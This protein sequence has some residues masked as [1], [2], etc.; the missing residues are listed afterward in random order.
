M[1]IKTTSLLEEKSNAIKSTNFIA[2]CVIALYHFA[3]F[4][5]IQGG[6]N[7]KVTWLVEYLASGLAMSVFFFVT[8]FLFFVNF[9]TVKTYF[10]KIKRR[11]HSLLIPYLFWQLI[12]CIIHFL[13]YRNIDFKT[14]VKTTFLLQRYPPDGPLWHMYAVFLLAIVSPLLYYLLKLQKFSFL[15]VFIL[16]VVF[17]HFSLYEFNPSYYYNHFAFKQ[18][19]YGYIP[20]I[21]RY[22][23]GYLFGAFFG[24]S[25]SNYKFSKEQ[26]LQYVMIILVLSF[27][28]EFLIPGIFFDFSVRLL[29]FLIIFS[30]PLKENK[31]I[32]NLSFLIYSLHFFVVEIFGSTFYNVFFQYTPFTSINNI[33]Y[34]SILF[35]ITLLVACAVHFSLNKFCKNF[36]GI[37]CGGRTGA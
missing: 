29:P 16:A 34:R 11:I 7:E 36:L 26:C 8:G 22:L 15:L 12:G 5:S 28:L 1:E 4:N 31:K 25:L 19:T 13:L 37:I 3:G 14:F 27:S 9:T 21:L 20:N 30:S 35:L 23:P 24:F 33:L 2:S 32:Y 10:L 17:R 18:C 6:V